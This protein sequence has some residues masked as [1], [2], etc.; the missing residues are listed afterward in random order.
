MNTR[1]LG[2]AL[3]IPAALFVIACSG[4]DTKEPQ[5]NAVNNA[6]GVATSVSL[7]GT[8]QLIN[9]TPALTALAGGATTPSSTGAPRP[10]GT[11]PAAGQP[12]AASSATGSTI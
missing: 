7:P 11:T 12:S 5:S 2:I 1:L 10:A 8:P 4:D 6:Q 9:A 3:L